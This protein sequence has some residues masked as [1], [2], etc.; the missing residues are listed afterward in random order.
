MSR[1]GRTGIVAALMITSGCSERLTCA[2]TG[3]IRVNPSEATVRIGETVVLR[4]EEGETPCGDR[5]PPF[6]PLPA[7][8]TTA[9][10]LI[11]RVDASTGGVVGLRVGDARIS[12]TPDG[13]LFT[14]V[15]VR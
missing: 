11:V 14:T 8:W 10:T 9:D 7:A 13:G 4:F 12:P 2:G 6:R 5:N 3:L 1:L 15:H